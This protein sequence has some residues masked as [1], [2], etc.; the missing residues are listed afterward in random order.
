M[1]HEAQEEHLVQVEEASKAHNGMILANDH[2]APL[3]S[4]STNAYDI[5][6]HLA[7][8]RLLC[9]IVTYIGST[10]IYMY[11]CRL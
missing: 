8:Q 6:R 10:T 4:F 3:S 7:I 9:S 1:Q 2:R 5:V 11:V